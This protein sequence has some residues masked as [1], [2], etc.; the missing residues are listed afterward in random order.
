MPGEIDSAIVDL[1][2]PCR[3]EFVG[4]VRLTILGVA[5]RMQFTYDE[6]EDIRLAVGE[7]CTTAI[8][9]AEKAGLVNT[10]ILVKSEISD[11]DLTIC[12]VDSIDY[13]AAP[14]DIAVSSDGIDEQ[15]IGAML[16][17][18]LVDEFKVERLADGGTAVT[19]IKRAG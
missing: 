2:V 18:L 4:I 12:I 7:A 5:S 6:I 3:A 13:T 8:D 16:M 9:R 15:N 19:M 10:D 11:G 14:A 1:R 17:E